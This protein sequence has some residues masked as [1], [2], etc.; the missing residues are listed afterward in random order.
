MNS[1]PPHPKTI[2]LVVCYIRMCIPGP[3]SSSSLIF[4]LDYVILFFFCVCLDY[5]LTFCCHL[6]HEFCVC[7]LDHAL[8]HPPTTPPHFQDD[9]LMQKRKK[10]KWSQ[11]LEQKILSLL[12]CHFSF[13]SPFVC[14]CVLSF[15]N[16]SFLSFTKK[17]ELLLMPP[18]PT[19]Q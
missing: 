18:P 14:V 10:R 3:F 11:G 19:H 15:F 6:R 1:S 5:L 16:A 17:E 8:A 2:D 13:F 12:Y 9:S 7:P 4:L